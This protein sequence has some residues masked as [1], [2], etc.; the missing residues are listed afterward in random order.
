MMDG[1]ILRADYW[2]IG[3]S[4]VAA[5]SCVE[6]KYEMNRVSSAVNGTVNAESFYINRDDTAVSPLERRALVWEDVP[7]TQ[8]VNISGHMTDL[9]KSNY[10]GDDEPPARCPW[11]LL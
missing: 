9:H 11:R 4:G 2:V 10:L 5:L 7:T 1:F 3:T 6:E 8:P